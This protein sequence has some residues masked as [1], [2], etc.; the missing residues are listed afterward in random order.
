VLCLLAASIPFRK[1][2]QIDPALV[3]RS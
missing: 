1:I 3:F 2:S